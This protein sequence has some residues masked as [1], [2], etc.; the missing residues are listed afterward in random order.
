MP[1]VR[2]KSVSSLQTSTKHRVNL[3]CHPD[4]NLC[5]ISSWMALNTSPGVRFPINVRSSQGHCHASRSLCSS[6][7]SPSSYRALGHQQ[8]PSLRRRKRRPCRWRLPN[9]LHWT[10][11]LQACHTYSQPV[12]SPNKDGWREKVRCIHTLNGLGSVRLFIP[13]FTYFLVTSLAAQSSTWL[14]RYYLSWTIPLLNSIMKCI[15]QIIE[16]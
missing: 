15:Q 5:L 16:C 13:F 10:E 1:K 11:R 3:L 9:S 4:R 7:V 6:Q 2:S 8:N 12:H 14:H